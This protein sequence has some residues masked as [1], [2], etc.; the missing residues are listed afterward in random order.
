MIQTSISENLRPQIIQTHDECLLD[1]VNVCSAENSSSVKIQCNM[2]DGYVE[3]YQQDNS[4][5]CCMKVLSHSWN[6]LKRMIGVVPNSVVELLI[7]AVNNRTVE[8]NYFRLYG[9][10]VDGTISEDEFNR[11]IEKNESEYV[12]SGEERPDEQTLITAL[13]LSRHIKDVNN[14]EDLSSLFSFDSV[15]VDACLE[16]TAVNGNLR[17]CQ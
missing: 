8:R 7:K 13:L 12:L 4:D 9:E 15:K 16:K 5:L 11:E 2:V 17:K 1:T 14:S 6:P 10:M 3:A